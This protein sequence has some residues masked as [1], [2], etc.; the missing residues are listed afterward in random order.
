MIDFYSAPTPNG[1]KISI[2]L[3][4]M[5]LEYQLKVV[6][7]SAGAQKEA[8]FLAMNPNGRI[9]VIVDHEADDLIIFESGAILMY[10]ADKT[11]LF[12]P[13][14]LVGKTAVQQWLMFQMSAIGPMMGQANVFTR[15]FPE[16]IEPVINRYQ[17][18]VARLFRVVDAQLADHEYLAGDYSIADMACWPWIRTHEWSG[19]SLDDCPNL[20]RW[21]TAVA[22]RPA[23][24]RGIQVPP[25]ASAEK[26]VQSGQSIITQ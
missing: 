6:D 7:L 19:V 11:G 22:A 25:S 24:Q 4:E 14:T 20:Q 23:V 3:E 13:E 5:E 2:A 9:P 21:V 15:Y 10:L 1:Y 17:N 16:R 18:E 12:M 26:V 8:A